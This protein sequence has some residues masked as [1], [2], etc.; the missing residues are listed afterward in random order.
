MGGLELQV[1]SANV[2]VLTEPQLKPTTEWQ[3]IA[4]D[5]ALKDESIRAIAG[6]E[7]DLERHLLEQ[8]RSRR[9]AS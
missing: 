8:E 9:L 5:S 1:V 6:S 3:A 4:R 7:A 2:V